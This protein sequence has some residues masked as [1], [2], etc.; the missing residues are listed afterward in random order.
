[1]VKYVTEIMSDATP[2]S[3]HLADM[4]YEV[5][6]SMGFDFAVARAVAELD[7]IAD[8]ATVA[9][10]MGI[11]AS[12]VRDEIPT[13]S[14]TVGVEYGAAVD[15]AVEFGVPT[16]IVRGL[17]TGSKAVGYQDSLNRIQAFFEATESRARIQA[18][19]SS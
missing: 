9:E 12:A 14:E 17:N 10:V 11:L 8:Q 7:Q 3:E 19:P 4:P 2:P 5:G 18:E 13:V 6:L 15:R 16:D 1:M